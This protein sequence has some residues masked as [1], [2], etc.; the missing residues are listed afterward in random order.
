[1]F[2]SNYNLPS[3]LSSRSIISLNSNSSNKINNNY[4]QNN[5]EDYFK[6]RK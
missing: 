2:N 6:K 4:S 5:E 1:M 3:P